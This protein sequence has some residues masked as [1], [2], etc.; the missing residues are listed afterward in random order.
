MAGKY[1]T[2]ELDSIFNLTLKLSGTDPMTVKR[3]YSADRYW[4]FVE[5]TWKN[6]EKTIGGNVMYT[7]LFHIHWGCYPVKTPV[8]PDFLQL[9]ELV[10][11]EF[12]KHTHE[13]EIA[14]SKRVFRSAY[15]AV[16]K[17]YSPY[18]LRKDE[19]KS[20]AYKDFLEKKTQVRLYGGQVVVHSLNLVTTPGREIQDMVYKARIRY[21]C[22]RFKRSIERLLPDARAWSESEWSDQR[23]IIDNMKK[24]FGVDYAVEWEDFDR[25][26]DMIEAVESKRTTRYEM[27]SVNHF[28][29][30]MAKM[31]WPVNTDAVLENMFCYYVTW[32]KDYVLRVK[33]NSSCGCGDEEM[34]RNQ[35]LESW[36]YKVM[37]GWYRG[38]AHPLSDKTRKKLFDI[39]LGVI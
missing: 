18:V 20:A 11:A 27:L 26:I 10:E 33:C 34:L 15:I 13:M 23:N 32:Y 19:W 6:A 14:K 21:A 36:L 29:Y 28:S 25:T 35:I 7:V 16:M 1:N 12:L 9:A 3:S 4:G 22:E 5:K 37:Y 17:S 30:D 24:T 39:S 8:N 38:K 2:P 31:L